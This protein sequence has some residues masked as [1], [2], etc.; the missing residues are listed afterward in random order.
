MRTWQAATACHPTP[1]E[2]AMP[3]TPHDDPIT[4]LLTGRAPAW[5][6]LALSAAAAL[7]GITLQLTIDV[8][9]PAL[10]RWSLGGGL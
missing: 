7:A 3:A 4:A 9:L 1:M 6:W 2:A 5:H 10:A 8:A